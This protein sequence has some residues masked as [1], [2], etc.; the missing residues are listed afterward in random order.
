M[1]FLTGLADPATPTGERLERLAAFTPDEKAR[2]TIRH[3]HTMPRTHASIELP[4]LQRL[5]HAHLQTGQVPDATVL[6]FF[7][8]RHA[9]IPHVKRYGSK[10][11]DALLATSCRA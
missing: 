8:L 9:A 3:V 1:R 10:Q 6:R 5:C 7:T 11:P 2:R 4:T